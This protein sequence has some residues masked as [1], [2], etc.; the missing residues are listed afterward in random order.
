MSGTPIEAVKEALEKLEKAQQDLNKAR[1]EIQ[2]L[3]NKVE[4]LETQLAGKADST[5]LQNTE[6]TLTQSIQRVET[7]ANSAQTTANTANATASSAQSAASSAQATA[8]QTVD[9]TQKISFDG[10][11]TVLSSPLLITV[12]FASGH[13]SVPLKIEVKTFKSSDNKSKSFY[14]VARTIN[15]RVFTLLLGMWDQANPLIL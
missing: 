9:R 4:S 12:P 15:L 11:T 7:L 6:R 1:S 8:N 5:T 14:L 3:K 13:T 2:D 10:T